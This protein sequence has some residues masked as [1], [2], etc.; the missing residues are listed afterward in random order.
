MKD[1][2][3]AQHVHRRSKQPLLSAD[4][5]YRPLQHTLP[6][7]QDN[8]FISGQHL[9]KRKK[10]RLLEKIRMGTS[11]SGGE[12]HAPKKRHNLSL[13]FNIGPVKK[14]KSV[15]TS[16]GSQDR[17]KPFETLKTAVIFFAQ[18]P[19]KIY[20][21]LFLVLA[22]GCFAL[23]FNY[24]PEPLPPEDNIIRG[25]GIRIEGFI[26]N[27]GDEIPL[28]VT[29]TFAWQYYSVRSGDSVEGI[30]RRFGLSLDA[31]IASNNLRNVRQLKA[32]Q[33]IRIPNMDG[34][35]YKVKRGDSY[36]KIAQSFDVPLEAVLDA[37]DIQNDEVHEDDV[38][39][40]PGARM[41]KN[42]LRRALGELFI[43]PISGRRSSGF[44]WRN[45]PFSGV[46]SFH[47][48]LD[49][50]GPTGMSVKASADGRVSATGYNATYGNFVIITHT[51]E[52]QTMYAHLNR[53]LVKNGTFVNQG[54]IIGQVGN[55]G[56]S[57][58]PHLHFS[59]YKNKVAINPLEVLNN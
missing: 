29:E 23:M 54:A 38:L 47:A 53:I 13:F 21:V 10:K 22:T 49:I 56:R 46:R 2:I 26:D 41:D 24:I 42:E 25:N 44:G 48:G 16:V 35:P 7:M 58:G 52:Y 4:Q 20:L 6:V 43:W 8:S 15:F 32:G 19:K 37:N 14:E 36:P 9:P 57:T 51:P 1:I 55:T 40:I 31:V 5:K 50:V 28:D 11:A 27:E 18:I 3:S 45:D 34:I 17:K 12:Y 59:V 33:S 30:S 39:F